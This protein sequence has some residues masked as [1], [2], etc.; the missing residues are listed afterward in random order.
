LTLG[1]ALTAAGLLAAAAA[2]SS[3]ETPSA[4][5]AP[6]A[7]RA[8]RAYADAGRCPA[9]V[10]YAAGRDAIQVYDAN[11]LKGGR[12]GRITGLV[13]PQGLL[14]DSKRNLWVVDPVNRQIN[15]FAPGT[16]AP[17][18][19]LRDTGGTPNAIALDEASGTAYVTEYK[20][21]ADATTLVQVYAGGSTTPTG[22][23]HDPAARNGGFAAVDSQGNV[24]VTFMTQDNKAQ[25]DRFAAGSSNPENLGLKLIS[26]GAIA[27]TKSGA[28]AICD[29]A[30]YRCGVFEL[31][32]KNISHVFGHM[33]MGRAGVRPDKAP[34]IIPEAFA[35][36]RGERHAYVAGGSVTQWAYPGPANRPNHT[37]QAEIKLPGFD[38]P[39]GGIAVSPASRPG[40]AYY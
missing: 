25:V 31:G 32:S 35:L 7:D 17:V 4:S 12:C 20:N 36:D 37:P 22:S 3:Q 9:A 30:A 8:A 1:R 38:N 26:A 23:L 16:H 21:D 18:L 14:V 11:N 29:P 2:C 33:G 27:T 28:L 6:T 40:A 5:F 39:A 24:Y 19:T 15:K 13:A 34:F 10:V